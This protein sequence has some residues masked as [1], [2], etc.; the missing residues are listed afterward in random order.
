MKRKSG[1]A[2]LWSAMKV[3]EDM[4][5]KSH[6][7]PMAIRA[8][9]KLHIQQG[10]SID[11]VA[12]VFGCSN[13]TV[14]RTV[15]MRGNFEV[16][17]HEAFHFLQPSS[18]PY[19]GKIRVNVSAPAAH[20]IRGADDHGFIGEFDIDLSKDKLN[21]TDKPWQRRIRKMLY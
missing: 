4:Q 17:W 19:F 2:E 18:D 9:E 14:N 7:P 20:Q 5:G 8:M 3:L 21:E 1:K 10:M 16:V 12:D 11:E 6:V 13:E 15:N